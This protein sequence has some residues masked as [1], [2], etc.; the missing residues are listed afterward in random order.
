MLSDV[1]TGRVM[2]G[3]AETGRERCGDMKT[4]RETSLFVGDMRTRG[5]V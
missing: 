1:D 3:Y 2:Y 4:G 5:D